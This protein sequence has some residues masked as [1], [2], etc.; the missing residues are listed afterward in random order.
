MPDALRAE[1]ARSDTTD[2]VA[3]AGF[4]HAGR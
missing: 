2:P 1:L 3:W 4:A